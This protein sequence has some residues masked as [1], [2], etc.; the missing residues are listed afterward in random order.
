MIQTKPFD[1]SFIRVHTP[2]YDSFQQKAF[3]YFDNAAT[4]FP[5]DVAV[6]AMNEYCIT[7]HANVHRGVSSISEQTTMEYEEARN[8]IAH[9]IGAHAN[10][11]IFTSGATASINMVALSWAEHAL[12]PGDEVVITQAEHHANYLVWQEFAEKFDVTVKILPIDTSTWTVDR[13]SISHV[14]TDKTKLVAVTQCSNVLG[15]IW[16]ADE[17]LLDLLII[18]ARECGAAVL[19]DGAQY[20]AH[21]CVDVG[22]LDIDFYAFSGHKIGAS[23]GIGV[24]YVNRR[25]HAEIIPAIV[26]GGMVYN[27]DEPSFKEMPYCLEAGTPPV[28]QALGLAAAMK[29]R[30]E[31]IDYHALFEHESRLT[32]ILYTSFC[33]VPG[34][35]LLVNH[36]NLSQHAH[37]LTLCVDG[38]H[39]HDLAEELSQ[40]AIYVRAG[41]HCAQSLMQLWQH[42]ATVR[43]SIGA[44]NTLEEAEYVA[45][46]VPEVIKNMRRVLHD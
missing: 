18:R 3:Y 38:I 42:Q 2:A 44:C 7:P 24:L 45:R 31:H 19:L 11:I 6:D 41:D 4:T 25:R 35:S 30:E 16:Q 9:C 22:S 36:K 26:G 14:I 10:E 28:A 1:P 40:H 39:A 43:F 27:I 37:L 20:V 46:I 23:T 17:E 13:A 34:V 32:Q 33:Q 5:L 21:N 15:S 8:T 12:R 29:F